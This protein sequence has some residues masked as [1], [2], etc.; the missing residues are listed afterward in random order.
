MNVIFL[1]NAV[2]EYKTDRGW[3]EFYQG[4]SDKIEKAHQ[5]KKDKTIL[6][7]GDKRLAKS[8]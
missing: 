4:L 5:K 2:W 8:F 1:V 7:E 3:K 6:S